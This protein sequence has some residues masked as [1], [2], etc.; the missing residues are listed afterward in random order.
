[1]LFYRVMYP[2]IWLL[3]GSARL[4]VRLFG[5]Q[6][7]NEQELAHSEEELRLLLSASYKNGEINHTEYK[8]VNNIFRLTI[9]SQKKLWFRAKK[10]L[11]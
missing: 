1:M 6:L 4:V 5:F 2:F 8:Y 9:V 11:R 3:N 10:L 7:S